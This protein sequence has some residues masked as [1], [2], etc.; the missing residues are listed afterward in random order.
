MILFIGPTSIDVRGG[1]IPNDMLDVPDSVWEKEKNG[2]SSV[3]LRQTGSQP[4]QACLKVKV[5]YNQGWVNSAGGGNV[6][7]AH[8]AAK[9]VIVKANEMYNTKFAAAN[10]L[11]TSIALSLVAG[12]H[13]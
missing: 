1:E 6:A 8:Q 11:G 12:K 2:S 4:T 5:I 9:D 3:N 10:R 13:C 7:T